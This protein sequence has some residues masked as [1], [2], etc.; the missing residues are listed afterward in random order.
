V[1]GRHVPFDLRFTFT[2]VRCPA[3]WAAILLVVYYVLAVKSAPF[4]AVAVLNG[5]VGKWRVVDGG[6]VV[7]AGPSAL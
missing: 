2:Y 5:G 6:R 4:F 1:W 3:L 7:A